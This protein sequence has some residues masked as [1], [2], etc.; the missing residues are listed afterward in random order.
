MDNV[1]ISPHSAATLTEENA[2]ITEIFVDNLRRW[3]D[4]R[5][6]RNRYDAGRGY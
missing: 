3:L 4:G 1:L 5:P 2:R 6:L